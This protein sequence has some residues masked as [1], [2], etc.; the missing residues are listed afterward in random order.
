MKQAAALLTELS[1]RQDLCLVSL[2]M[3]TLAMMVL[4]MPTEAADVLIAFSIGLSLLL[5]MAA[6]YLTSPADFS[7]LPGLILLTTI[8]RLSISVTTSRLVLTEADAGEI[9][10]TFGEFVISGNVVVGL[11]VFLIISVVQFMVVT[12]GAERVA[13]VA[14]R[15]ALDAMP[16]KQMAIDNDAR[17]GAIKADEA[18]RRRQSLERESQLFG[19]MDGAMKFVKG[20]AIASLMIIAVNL[21]GGIAIGCAQKGMSISEAGAT[22]SLLA[23]GDGLIAQ[24]PALLV[25]LTA[26]LVVTRVGADGETNLGIDIIRQ[27]GSDHRTLAVAGAILGALCLVPGFPTVVFLLLGASLTGGGWLLQR[28]RRRGVAAEE[29]ALK[30]AVG[31][32]RNTAA[33]MQVRLGNDLISARDAVTRAVTQL[34]DQMAE[35]LGIGLPHIEVLEAGDPNATGLCLE[36]NHVPLLSVQMHAGES[37]SEVPVA[38]SEIRIGPGGRQ[39]SVMQGEPLD[40]SSAIDAVAVVVRFT[41]ETMLRAAGKLVGIQET[42]LLVNRAEAAYGDL[43]REATR[44]APL[45]RLAEVFRR[46]VAEGVSLRDMRQ[47]L[48]AVAEWGPRESSPA[49]LS[50]CVRV[51]LRQQICHA[52]AA[53]EMTLR[54]LLIQ[55]DLAGALLSQVQQTMSGEVLQPDNANA[56]ID[57]VRAKLQMAGSASPVVIITIMDLRR[58]FRAFLGR[59]GIDAAVMSHEELA[60]GFQVDVVGTIGRPAMQRPADQT[61]L[62]RAQ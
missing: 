60:S 57:D 44:A 15:F 17:T 13:E 39:W 27:I 51:A 49:L 22:Y 34:R 8:F 45:P 6:V 21:I 1:R 3:T 41:R 58:H 53:A 46:L 9:I 4:P 2:I 29:A 62:E 55:D 52:A 28:H 43:V 30:E 56:L 14:A 35:E 32:R 37:W 5:L 42:Q 47:V 38:G 54:A 40:R 59:Y 19:A 23:I 10:R 33:A 11:V 48:E 12:K 18:K 24:I 50:E 31:D 7:T 20:D 36:M 16:G 61:L 26:G 25:S